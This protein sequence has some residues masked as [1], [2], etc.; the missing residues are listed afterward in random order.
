MYLIKINPT[1]SGKGAFFLLSMH[2]YNK[3]RRFLIKKN[4]L[5]P[6]EAKHYLME[7]EDFN[8]IYGTNS[9]LLFCSK[10]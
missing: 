10:I 7:R 6:F 1:L 9:T 4:A 5:L 8:V 3:Q 2:H